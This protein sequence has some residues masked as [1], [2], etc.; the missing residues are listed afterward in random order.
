[1][2]ARILTLTNNDTTLDLSGV[3]EELFAVL[4][5]AMTEQAAAVSYQA[6]TEADEESGTEATPVKYTVN[7]TDSYDS[8]ISI[9]VL[10][11]DSAELTVTFETT[12]QTTAGEDGTFSTYKVNGDTY[13][14]VSGA[15]EIQTAGGEGDT[16]LT[17][18]VVLI[19]ADEDNSQVS[20]SGQ[21]GAEEAPDAI[22][23]G[24]GD[25]IVTVTDG[26]FVSISGINSGDGESFSVGTDD[27]VA[28]GIGLIKQGTHL[29]NGTGDIT[30]SDIVT[31]EQLEDLSAIKEAANGEIVINSD[32]LLLDGEETPEDSVVFVDAVD[33]TASKLYAT[34]DSDGSL[35]SSTD[36]A[37]IATVTIEG[38]EVSVGA[39]F[40]ADTEFSSTYTEGDD[41]DPEGGA[42]DEGDDENPEGGNGGNSGTV[43]F[44]VTNGA[45][46]N[47]NGNT[48]S[49][50]EITLVEGKLSGVTE[51]QTIATETDDTSI[52]VTA[53][54]IAYAIELSQDEDTGA[55][56]VALTG[57]DRE[58]T[59]ELFGLEGSTAQTVDDTNATTYTFGK[60]GDQTFTITGDADG[61][62]F[63]VDADGYVTDITGLNADATVDIVSA[64]DV[65]VNDVTFTAEEIADEE[66]GFTAV[67]TQEG[68]SAAK[69]FKGDSFLIDVTD[70]GIAIYG[71]NED[72]S[73]ETETIAA[74]ETIATYE[75]GV[76]TLGSSVVPSDS[77]KVVVRNNTENAVAVNTSNDNPYF[78]EFTNNNV[79]L[80]IGENGALN[81]VTTNDDVVAD[82]TASDVEGISGSI[83]IPA[84]KALT[85]ADDY[86]ITAGTDEA[87]VTFGEEAI[88]LNG[89]G[90]EV[91][92]A[93]EGTTFT[94]T[95][96]ATGDE[97][98]EEPATSYAPY[99]IND[100]SY[101][102]V[103]D[104]TFEIGAEG[105]LFVSGEIIVDANNDVTAQ[106]GDTISFSGEEG[107]GV[108]VTA[109]EGEITN[110]GD[111]QNGESITL[112]DTTYTMT[113]TGIIIDGDT[114]S[115]WKDADTATAE[116]FTAD[117]LE[118]ADNWVGVIGLNEGV[119]EIN[120]DVDASSELLVVDDATAPTVRYGTLS[121]AEAE[122]GAE[123]AG[124]YALTNEGATNTESD[125]AI[126]GISISGIQI[127][128]GDGFEN[129]PVTANDTTT[130]EVD[131][132]YS[133][134]ATGD[135]VALVADNSE[136]TLTSGTISVAEGTVT[137][138][139]DTTVTVGEGGYTVALENDAVTVSAVNAGAVTIEGNATVE[140]VAFDKETVTY[141]FGEGEDAQTFTIEGD[142][143]G[144]TF[145]VEDGVVTK[146]AGL[147]I[148]AILT[149]TTATEV[150]VNEQED[151]IYSG[152][153][154]QLVGTGSTNGENVAE[155][156]KDSSFYVEITDDGLTVYVIEDG[157]ITET[158]YDDPESYSRFFSFANNTLTIN[159]EE[160]FV[161]SEENGNILVVENKTE[162]EVTLDT[163]ASGLTSLGEGVAVK[164]VS[165]NSLQIVNATVGEALAD[166]DRPT[167][168]S[169]TV[170]AETTLTTN[171]VTVTA[172]TVEAAVEF[173]ADSVTVDGAGAAI[174][175]EGTF[176]LVA[177]SEDGVEYTLNDENINVISTATVTTGDELTLNSGT[178]KTNGIAVAYGAITVENDEDGVKVVVDD[179]G[180]VTEISDLED[181][182]SV[183]YNGTT[184]TMV[185]D[186]LVVV[187][188]NA[189][190]I[191][192]NSDTDTNILSL[193]GVDHTLY[194]Q[195]DNDTIDMVAGVA[196]INEGATA[197]IYGTTE[198]YAT[199]SVV[200]TL[201]YEDGAANLT[202]GTAEV[203]NLTVD[204]SGVEGITAITADFAATVNTPATTDAVTVNNNPYVSTD[205]SS[206]TVDATADGSTLNTGTVTLAVAEEGSEEE[207]GVASVT[208]TTGDAVTVTNGSVTATAAEGVI[209]E[210]GDINSGE[211]F[212]IGDVE[213]RQVDAGLLKTEDNTTSLLDG[214]ES[215]DTFAPTAENEWLTVLNVTEEGVLDISEVSD[216]AVVFDSTLTTQVADLTFEDG[217][218]TLTP[219]E[220]VEDT[221]ITTIQLGTENTTIT[222]EFDTQV[223]SAEDSE[224]V[225]VNNVTYIPAE[226]TLTIAATA[227]GSSL[228]TGSVTLNS[229]NA[230]V[231]VGD[232]TI[233]VEGEAEATVTADEGVAVSVGGLNAGES[234][235]I[236]D[237][238][239]VETGIGLIKRTPR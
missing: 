44:K 7:K 12:V 228:Y 220:G 234:F 134:D 168:G 143:D 97:G 2:W 109:A 101:A 141:T 205:G 206:L 225:T 198:E 151:D 189:T 70:E 103:Q 5:D 54:G 48:V 152:T 18:G 144:V 100:K 194:I 162:N 63:T 191:Y 130:F 88:T 84:T 117:D 145:T 178:I 86:T 238:Q 68:T 49:A 75:D 59:V 222:A 156:I 147:D 139:G 239:Y 4:N 45:A 122:E 126:E 55:N 108:N 92:N 3:N 232:D 188:E 72:G 231:T 22:V 37:D 99:T 218:Y 93:P 81:F 94:A 105:P 138:A 128:V 190:N 8:D 27:Y 183:T 32:T 158:S 112:N 150:Q 43:K 90:I 28:S 39:G 215:A 107:N 185:G 60:D 35:A 211:E 69:V 163:Y 20:P 184:Y 23:A 146:V 83:T 66:E 171:D 223:V 137:T 36:V 111:I 33:S 192:G 104:A 121:Q 216:N 71:V 177:D 229:D 47:V 221:G 193:D 73:I 82:A 157:T 176:V 140:T 197:A 226:G 160:G 167:E 200:A 85:L 210:I 21:E 149:M 50:T 179:E 174:S 46:F 53:E 180:A 1:M 181:G 64:Q 96:I 38:V 89:A 165:S 34:Y 114:I 127:T 16:T 209:T 9:V 14:P 214:S 155:L 230:S 87:E 11:A 119:L 120:S 172:G 199:D 15:L 123:T 30:E 236:N 219:A 170:A 224:S 74:P 25:F 13:A 41:E 175:G 6:A 142:S 42:G 80:Q 202:A 237:D 17:N 227:D 116:T 51:E 29:V 113:A 40:S 110:I 102:V 56:V 235:T 208:P 136:V 186:Q 67:G 91:A 95:A 129:I 77:S 196:G 166:A 233:T 154:V 207:G 57:I 131:G 195:V 61:V 182:V 115:I 153:E 173:G 161:P 203:E 132:S 31:V 133:V 201:T 79:S 62:T 125:A 65:T 78:T 98:E 148:Q 169:I 76:I 212:T 24:T 118:N 52:K 10:G 213:Y 187:D 124:G 204:A 164:V 217:A 26:E 19:S 58:A 106:G 159:T 135:V